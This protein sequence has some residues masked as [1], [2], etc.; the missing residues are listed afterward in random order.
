[1]DAADSTQIS[2]QDYFATPK[3]RKITA[4]I[5]AAIV[6]AMILGAMLASQKPAVEPVQLSHSLDGSSTYT[7]L[8]VQLLSEWVYNVSGDSN[9]T[10]YQAMDPDG[11]WYIV[12]L[13]DDFAEQFKPYQDAYNYVLGDNAPYAEIPEPYR[14]TG[15][16]YAISSNDISSLAS[17]YSVTETQYTDFFGT[18]Y[19][20][21]GTNPG[22]AALALFVIGAAFS[23]LILLILF[24]ISASV[25]NR[26]KKSDERLYALGKSDDAE[27]EF[28]AMDNLRFEKSKLVLSEHFAYAGSTGVVASYE[29]IAWLYKYVQRSHGIA[30]STQLIAGLINGRTAAL[31]TRFVTDE[32]IEQAV[33]KILQ[34]NPN[35]LVGYSIDNARQYRARVKEFKLN[36]R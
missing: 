13:D 35:V 14:I 23:G 7:Y 34:Q 3:S 6:L 4:V 16:T 32:L 26:F 36:N 17:P 1:M 29:D 30:V 28:T 15:M 25:Q 12:A 5:L 27:F 18:Y 33:V 9:Y 8:D 11:N 20:D 22:N 21:E 31:A 19:L 10:Y 24:A 2:M